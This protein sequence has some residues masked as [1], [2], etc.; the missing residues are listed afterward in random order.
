MNKI[1]IYL[2]ILSSL[3]S[4]NPPEGAN[5]LTDIPGTSPSAPSGIVRLNPQMSIGLDSTPEFTVSGVVS[6]DTI[7]LFTDSSCSS[8]VASVVAAA[9]SVNITT[10]SPLIIG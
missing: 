10:A 9:S 3:I 6:G 1:L 5:S 8:E 7:K 2:L 4:C